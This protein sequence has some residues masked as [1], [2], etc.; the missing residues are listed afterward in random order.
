MIGAGAV[1]T[2]TVPPNAVVVGNPASIIRYVDAHPR[3]T[4]DAPPREDGARDLAL[5]VKGVHTHRLPLFSDLRGRLAV[6]EL[7][8]FLPFLPQ[9][10][11]VV[12]DV[13][14]REVRGEHAHKLLHQFLVCVEGECSLMVDDGLHRAEIRL[15]SPAIGVHLEPMVWG[16]QYKFS[17]DAILLVLA[18]APYDPEEYIR[19]YE[20]Y[21][22]L[23]FRKGT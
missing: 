6:A 19:E 20:K 23:V 4:P 18:S 10:F 17:P 12:Y 21:L 8:E 9:R 1:V 15:D 13:P 14:S 2:K 16:V 11:F 5:G 22:S 7:A 3:P